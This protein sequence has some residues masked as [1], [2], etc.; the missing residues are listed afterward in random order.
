MKVYQ[1]VVLSVQVNT[2][3]QKKKRRGAL[4]SRRFAVAQRSGQPR[5]A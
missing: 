4:Q 2:A 5:V 1:P 3:R